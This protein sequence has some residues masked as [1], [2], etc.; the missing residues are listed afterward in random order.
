MGPLGLRRVS[1]TSALGTPSTPSGSQ[2]TFMTSCSPRHA[3]DVPWPY[4]HNQQCPQAG[5]QVRPTPERLHDAIGPTPSTALAAA[6]ARADLVTS[7]TGDKHGSFSCSSSNLVDIDPLGRQH[8]QAQLPPAGCPSRWPVLVA[9]WPH[10]HSQQCPQ[11]GRLRGRGSAGPAPGLRDIG[12][13]D[14]L[15]TQR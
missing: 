15:N 9:G 8:Q 11:A 2:R 13:G 4:C 5:R 1:G 7:G 14:T 3:G 10:C 6:S 12:P